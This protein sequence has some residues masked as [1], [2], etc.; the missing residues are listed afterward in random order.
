MHDAIEL[1]PV[2]F[3]FPTA[4]CSKMSILLLNLEVDLSNLPGKLSG[5]ILKHGRVLKTPRES[6]D[7]LQVGRTEGPDSLRTCDKSTCD[8]E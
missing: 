1:L 6:F 8:L 7:G 4:N 2:S 5:E 3:S